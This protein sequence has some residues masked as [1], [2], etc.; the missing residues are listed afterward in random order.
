M[1][2][3]QHFSS[4]SKFTS[5]LVDSGASIAVPRISHSGK[6]AAFKPM[7]ILASC[8]Y[9]YVEFDAIMPQVAKFGAGAID[10]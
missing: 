2:D 1:P 10:I 7:Y 5:R 4:R 8:I 6:S 9:G 3:N